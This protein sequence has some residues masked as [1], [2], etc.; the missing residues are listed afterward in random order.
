VVTTM[1]ALVIS[2]IHG[3]IEALR[4]LEAHWGAR[5]QEFDRIICLGDLLDYGPSPGEVIDWVR[6][7]TTNVVRGNH[8][9]AVATGESCKSAPAFLEASVLT[10]LRLQPTLSESQI[11]YLKALPLTDT[12]TGIGPNGVAA[13]HLVHACPSDPLYAYMPPQRTDAEW[14]AA[15]DGV[16]TPM[17]LIGHTHL[18]FVRPVGTGL[19][20]NPGS[21]G[22]PKDGDPH[23]SYVVL[24]GASVQFCRIAYD[25]EP[26]IARL[27][28]LNLP[29]H[30]FNQLAETF[31]TGT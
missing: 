16:K 5:L 21:L 14:A 29:A 24:D 26:L 12:V 28:A 15:L 6:S 25:P 30:V 3:N 19:V 8:D 1:R 9:H 18:A 31:R 20:I 11:D 17:T 22:M 27:Q 7:H 4:A 2:D 10:R 13:L 23:G